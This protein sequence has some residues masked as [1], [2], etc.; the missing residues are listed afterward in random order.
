[1][2]GKSANRTKNELISLSRTVSHALRHAPDEYG[3]RLDRLGW[4]EIPVLLQALGKRSK[5]WEGL[6][7]DDLIAMAGA[8]EKQRYEF[9]GS[10]IR[11]IYGHSIPGP[12]E[13]VEAVP[14]DILLH[15]TTS[16]F[17]AL[18]LEQGLKSMKRQYVHLSAEQDTAR[19]V[20]LRRTEHPVLLRID[21]KA[22]YEVGT[23]FYR[24]NEKVWLATYI[25]SK[26][27]S[28]K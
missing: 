2:S 21:A 24:G 5:R 17:A 10:R 11:A 12:I 3:M 7:E 6:S 1:M 20:A 15:G 22:A 19:E 16:E 26:F 23:K 14:P 8:G 27:I 28:E 18:I 25:D 13:Y 9:E 4:I